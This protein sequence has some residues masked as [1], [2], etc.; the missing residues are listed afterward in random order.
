MTHKIAWEKWVDV[1]EEEEQDQ[2]QVVEFDEEEFELMQNLQIIRTPLGSYQPHEPMNPSS[3]FDCWIIHTNF[4]VTEEIAEIIEDIDGIETFK[5]MSR[6]RMFIG[7]GK[8][9]DFPTVRQEIQRRLIPKSV[10]DQIDEVISTIRDK[11]Q[12]AIYIGEDGSMISISTDKKE[13]LDYL[14]K[15]NEIRSKKGG[16]ILT[17]EEF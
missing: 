14:D 10:S 16:N 6:Y 12:W 17:H 13:D 15:L 4:D 2:E 11:E 5:I 3:M 9:F 1:I 7:I 8:L